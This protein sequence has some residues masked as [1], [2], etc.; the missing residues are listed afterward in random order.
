MWRVQGVSELN[1][2]RNKP[3]GEGNNSAPDLGCFSRESA[4]QRQYSR[5]F[6]HHL[7]LSACP[8]TNWEDNRET[9]SA[10]KMFDWGSGGPIRKGVWVAASFLSEGKRKM[11]NILFMNKLKSLWAHMNLDLLSGISTVKLFQMFVTLQAKY[12]NEIKYINVSHRP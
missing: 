5:A 1:E 9:R 10:G 3:V 12:F 4:V 8:T 11:L 6:H 7:L 2:L